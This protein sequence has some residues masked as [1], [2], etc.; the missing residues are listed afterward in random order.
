MTLMPLMLALGV[1]AGP[2]HAKKN[3]A[4]QSC[5]SDSAEERGADTADESPG[6]LMVDEQTMNRTGRRFERQESWPRFKEGVARSRRRDSKE[7]K[8]LSSGALCANIDAMPRSTMPRST[9]P[10]S[11]MPRSTM[12]ALASG[13]TALADA[14]KSN[15]HAV[16]KLERAI[17]KLEKAGLEHDTGRGFVL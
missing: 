17:K 6:C 7:D 13:Q 11:T 5:S 12:A 3:D 8:S 14:I 15:S 9:M 2:A 10:R 16:K 1:A 4:K